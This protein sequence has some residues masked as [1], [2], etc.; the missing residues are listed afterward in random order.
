MSAAL[1]TY[2]IEGV[3]VKRTFLKAGAA[4]GAVSVAVLAAG[5]A[6]AATTVS[7][8]SA[9]AL[10][11]S[12][13]GNNVITQSVTAT[14]D[15]TTQTKNS[16]NTV[17]PLAQALPTNN[18]IGAGVVVQDAQALSNSTSAACAGLAGTGATGGV[19]SIGS[20]GCITSNNPVS[21]QLG[22]LQLGNATLDTTSVVGSL[23][24][25][26]PLLQGLA[27]LLQTA[28]INAINT[29]LAN[30]PLN[31]GL[32]GSLG[33]V[34]A[35]CQANPTSATG[36]ANITDS[37]ITLNIPGQQP[38]VLTSL[39]AHPSVNEQVILNP[40]ALVTNIRDALVSELDNAIQGQLAQVGGVVAQ[41]AGQIQTAL[42]VPL[43]TA[44]Q[45]L[46]QALNTNVAS[47]TLNEQTSPAP[48][49][50]S[51]SIK[52]TALDLKVLPVLGNNGIQ[53]TIGNVECGPNAK[54]AVI[55]PTPTPTKTPGKVPTGIESG[56]A[57]GSNTGTIIAAM[58]VLLAAGGAAGTAAYRRYWMPRG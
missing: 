45:P 5:P 48:G 11:L 18:L 4:L 12:A 1:G 21:L 27:P 32:G 38:I 53:A 24:S 36:T 16:G 17:P 52:V 3:I 8:A 54:A 58:S 34:S 41:A 42:L 14:N 23:V 35:H 51:P 57:G 22:N 31:I 2:V 49:K 43:Q 50:T 55:T 29:A 56:L 20:N 28:L 33:V 7:Q 37:N 39:P 6:M 9:Q 46:L 19:A 25:S 30:T 40:N 44:L 47:L 13:V 10:T 26:I 15:G